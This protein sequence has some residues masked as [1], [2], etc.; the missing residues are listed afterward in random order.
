[1]VKFIT[2][3]YLADVENYELKLFFNSNNVICV[4]KINKIKKPF[5]LNEDG[6]LIKILDNNYYILEIVP[7]DQNYIARIHLNEHGDIIE[8][9]F[10][11]SGENKIIDKIPSFEDLKLSYVCTNHGS[12]VYNQDKFNAML[13]DN[14]ISKEKHI[15]ILE[16][17]E[18]LKNQINQGNNEL[19]NLNYKK[20]LF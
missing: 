8:R 19:Y 5:I 12:K 15:Y 3:T 6:N 2:S 17:F 7:I 13:K 18:I 16:Q 10:T 14:K 11:M 1:M 4:K 20:Y 9:F